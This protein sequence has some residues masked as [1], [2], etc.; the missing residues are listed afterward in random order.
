[1][2]ESILIKTVTDNIKSLKKDLKFWENTGHRD[3]QTIHTIETI[4]ED[5]KNEQ[6]KINQVKK[7]I[8]RSFFKG[9]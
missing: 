1:M 5:I 9:K 7:S 3:D 4:K 8:E 2:N 6:W